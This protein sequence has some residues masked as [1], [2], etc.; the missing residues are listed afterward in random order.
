MT[1]KKLLFG[2]IKLTVVAGLVAIIVTNINWVDTLSR[3]APDGS[4]DAMA[5]RII[6]KW[7]QDPIQFLIGDSGE[8]IAVSRG[9]QTDGSRTTISPGLVTYV[10]NLDGALFALGALL[11]IVFFVCINSRWWFL[12]RANGLDVKFTEAQKYGWIGLFFNNVLPGATGGDVA[13]A[14]Y[15]ARRCS[16][17]KIRAVVSIVVDRIIGLLSLIFVGSLASLLAMDRFPVFA[18]T[19]WLTGLAALCFCF[20]LISPGLRRLIR[21][22]RLVSLLPMKI[23][24]IIHELDQAVMHYRGHL[25]GIGL[26]ILMSPIIYT[27]FVGSF[28]CMAESLGVGITL[29]DLFF[30][31]PVASVVQGIPVAPAGW[32]IGEAAYGYL[33]GKFGA[34]NLVGVAGAE[35]IMR[36]RGVALSVLHRIHAVAWSLL[37]GLFMLTEKKI[38]RSETDTPK[39]GGTTQ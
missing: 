3:T 39:T 32:G 6:G 33:I 12:L 23:G 13:K 29:S 19:I 10:K 22:D 37:G 38:E 17:E 18:S 25:G 21:F 5:G 26:W 2:A 1:K 9:E 20:L 30:I 36:T 24:T 7:D 11:F 16:G 34:V 4:V 8:P 28:F 35:E 27:L 15:I 14:V 31:V